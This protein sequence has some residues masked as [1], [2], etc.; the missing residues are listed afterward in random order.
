MRLTISSCSGWKTAPENISPRRGRY[1]L[2]GVC[3][4]LGIEFL[5]KRMENHLVWWQFIQHLEEKTASLQLIHERHQLDQL[6][7]ADLADLIEDL[8]YKKRTDFYR[9]PGR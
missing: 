8:D 9:R 1:R 5:F 6:H 3:S 2:T 7:P 4:R